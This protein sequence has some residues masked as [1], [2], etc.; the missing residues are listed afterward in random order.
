MKI[1]TPEELLAAEC[2]EPY[3]TRVQLLKVCSKLGRISSKLGSD[4]SKLGSFSS[5]RGRNTALLT[6]LFHQKAAVLDLLAILILSLLA[7]LVYKYKYWR[8]A[9]VFVPRPRAQKAVV[10]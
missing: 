1:L 9:S 6:T 2:K 5:K 10:G 7:F 3:E 8:C 4:S